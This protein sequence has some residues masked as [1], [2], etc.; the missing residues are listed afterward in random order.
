MK[1]HSH[2]YK[3]Y[4]GV[5]WSEEGV[6]GERALKEIEWYKFQVQNK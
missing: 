1:E 4:N 5:C 2:R 6:R 3:E